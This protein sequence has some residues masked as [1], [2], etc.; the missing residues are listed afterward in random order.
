MK[1]I[2]NSKEIEVPNVIVCP[3]DGGVMLLDSKKRAYV[4]INVEGC[5]NEIPLDYYIEHHQPFMLDR[6]FM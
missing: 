4:C 3:N 6:E 1:V 5:F 2:Y